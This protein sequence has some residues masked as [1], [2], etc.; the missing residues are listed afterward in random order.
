MFRLFSRQSAERAIEEKSAFIRETAAVYGVP[1]SWIK[2][3]LLKE[4]TELNILDPLADLVMQTSDCPKII[5]W[6]RIIRMIAG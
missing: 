1:A 5:E 4:M 6:T 3:I 2:G